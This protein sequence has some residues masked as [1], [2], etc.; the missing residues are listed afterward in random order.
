MDLMPRKRMHRRGGLGEARFLTFSCL[1][2][3]HY[4]QATATR[5]AVRESL[6]TMV[7]VDAL[8]VH[9][10]VIMGNHIHLLV[11]PRAE[12]IE[13]ALAVLK[14]S[15]VRTLP[16]SELPTQQVWERGGGF[17]RV[18][19]SERAY[20][21]IFSYIHMNPVRAGLVSM[22]EDW[23]WSS[24]RDWR[25]Q[26]RKTPVVRHPYWIEPWPQPKAERSEA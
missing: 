6:L 10:W 23:Q 7:E 22:P 9:A 26:R 4:L 15:L 14:S 11:T 1:E 20:W 25:R 21:N 5:H 16:C 18:V 19:W 17:D 8:A 13:H 3:R 24:A 2:G 12:T